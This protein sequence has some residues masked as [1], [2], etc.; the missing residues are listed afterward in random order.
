LTFNE[1]K[2]RFFQFEKVEF[3][4]A[5]FMILW[6]NFRSVWL[7]PTTIFENCGTGRRC[8]AL[9][10]LGAVTLTFLTTMP[11]SRKKKHLTIDVSPY[12]L[13]VKHTPTP[14]NTTTTSVQTI[15]FKVILGQEKKAA[16]ELL[17]FVYEQFELLID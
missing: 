3:V 16:K 15:H 10:K 5:L 4:Q 17:D 13:K 6:E 12:K 2:T 14:D 1:N 8:N 11:A 7:D 9:I